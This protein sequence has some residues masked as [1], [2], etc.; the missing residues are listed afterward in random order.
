MSESMWALRTS[1]VQ[2][3]Q[4]STRSP[5]KHPTSCLVEPSARSIAPARDDGLIIAAQPNRK[6]V[7]RDLRAQR[8]SNAPVA[9]MWLIPRTA[10]GQ[11]LSVQREQTAPRLLALR[12]V[13][14]ARI[15]RPPA[16]RA[17]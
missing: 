6:R 17:P 7:V 1:P 11:R 16:L 9:A 13:V 4:R 3:R 14:H 2:A 12:L 15:R 8:M 5:Q 10:S